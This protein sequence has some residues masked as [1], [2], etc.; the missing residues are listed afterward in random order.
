MLC[1]FLTVNRYV[2]LDA[3]PAALAF[4]SP[5][6]AMYAVAEYSTSGFLLAYGGIIGS[7]VARGLATITASK[8]KFV[9]S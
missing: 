7:N 5:T 6:Q 3:L 9:K 4:L 1:S 2:K 8:P